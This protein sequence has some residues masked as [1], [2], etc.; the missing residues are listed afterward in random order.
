MIVA[1]A[2]TGIDPATLRQWLTEAQKAYHT[3]LI[4]GQGVSY[5]YTQGDGN[6]SVTYTKADLPNLSGHIAQLQAA[7]GIGT[8]RAFRIRYH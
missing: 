6:K 8:R 7:L 5:N 3:L 2:L 4:G 1:G